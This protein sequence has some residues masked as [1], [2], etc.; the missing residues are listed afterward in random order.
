MVSLGL[1]VSAFAQEAARL[2]GEGKTPLFAAIDGRLAAALSVADAIKPTSAAAIHA[3]HAM[4]VKTAMITGDTER[5]ARAIAAQ[6]GI[7]EVIAGVLPDGKVA[8]L[9]RLQGRAKNR[10]RRRRRQ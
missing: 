7:D 2:A 4:G 6:A 9:E 10:F 1:D 8:A 5:T 3:L